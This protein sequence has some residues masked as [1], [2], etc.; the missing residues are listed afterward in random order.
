MS[1][2]EEC[3]GLKQ[4]VKERNCCEIALEFLSDKTVSLLLPELVKRVVHVLQEKMKNHEESSLAEVV[5]HVLEEKMFAPIVCHEL[6]QKHL[7]SLLPGLL[8]QFSCLKHM[9][10]TI[11]EENVSTWVFDMINLAM[12]SLK[13]GENSELW[14]MHMN[15]WSNKEAIHNGVRCDGCGI[16]PIQG[17]R[18]KCSVCPNFD[19]CSNCES[20]GKHP[21]SHPLLK[22]IRPTC[23]RHRGSNYFGGLQE[24]TNG[25]RCHRRPNGCG[26]PQSQGFGRCSG[27]ARRYHNPF[28]MS[29]VFGD[30]MCPKKEECEENNKHNKLQNRKEKL[31]EKL[32]KVN[33]KLGDNVEEKQPCDRPANMKEDKEY[34]NINCV[35]GELLVLMP[36]FEA[37]GRPGVTCDGCG[38]DCSQEK[39]I[40][41]CPVKRSLNHP[42]GYDICWSCANYSKHSKEEVVK[43][44][45]EIAVVENIE[46]KKDTEETI[47]VKNVENVENG[48]D[49]EEITVVENVEN[50]KDAEEIAV[51][52][53]IENEKDVEVVS[54]PFAQFEY[55]EQARCLVEMGFSDTEQI[56]SLLVN[57][58]G[59][60]NQVIAVLFPQ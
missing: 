15:S 45:E 56:M 11:N 20:T 58:N 42:H 16:S 37:Y 47:V 18:Y 7:K 54:D 24:M 52:E 25:A 39:V 40:Y 49:V 8:E 32:A 23:G 19:L 43:A 57:K 14:N 59:D 26:I 38:M 55:A 46:N 17:I 41:H 50:G 5:L 12:M 4:E 2:S 21:I 51:V 3:I 33:A 35:C 22:M 9:L 34:S 60:L 13:E 44:M 36:P 1:G 10:L 53:N 6:Y 28:W 27:R 48:K 31:M 30:S 29:H